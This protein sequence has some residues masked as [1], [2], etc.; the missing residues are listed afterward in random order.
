[1]QPLGGT[2]LLFDSAAV[3][4]QVL[5][6]LAGERWAMAGWFHEQSQPVPSWFNEAYET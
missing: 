2:L 5:E 6:T 4:H 1:M 3:L